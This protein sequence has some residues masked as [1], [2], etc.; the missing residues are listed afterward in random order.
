MRVYS[1]GRDQCI[2]WWQLTL[3][4]NMAAL[5]HE[6]SAWFDQKENYPWIS[7]CLGVSN[8]SASEHQS[9]Q[10]ELQIATRLETSLLCHVR[11]LM[12]SDT[13]DTDSCMGM[14]KWMAQRMK[15]DR[16]GCLLFGPILSVIWANILSHLG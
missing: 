5:I 11:C 6:Y 7:L 13:C 10:L 2:S 16:E 1:L 8:M 15:H 12:H 14:M 4:L 9:L 3:Y